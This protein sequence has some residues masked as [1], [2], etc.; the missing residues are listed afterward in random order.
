MLHQFLSA[1]TVKVSDGDVLFHLAGVLFLSHLR[2]IIAT[3]VD[4]NLS[5]E[6]SFL[7][8]LKLPTSNKLSRICVS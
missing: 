4:V 7:K 8:R 6:L 2:T 5:L 1:E 3:S